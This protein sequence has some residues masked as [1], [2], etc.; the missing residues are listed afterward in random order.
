MI[1]L[2]LNTSMPMINLINKF[3]QST[4]KAGRKLIV[5]T[6]MF[7]LSF[8]TFSQEASKIF[9]SDEPFDPKSTGNFYIAVDNLN[10]FKN[11]E[12]KSEYATGY[13]LTGAWI[14]PKL[15]Y[16]PDKKFRFEIGGQVLK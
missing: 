2:W 10:F 7:M 1:V 5:T 4:S 8:C 9:I 13:T 11:N 14:R 15:I 12:Y 16:Y 6:L 3:F